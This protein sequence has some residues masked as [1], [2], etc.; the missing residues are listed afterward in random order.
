MPCFPKHVWPSSEEP[1][2]K[3]RKLAKRAGGLR[4]LLRQGLAEVRPSL[5]EALSAKKNN[6][7][8]RGKEVD[9]CETKRK[10]E[11]VLARLDAI[12]GR[13]EPSSHP[14]GDTVGSAVI[15]LSP[16]LQVEHFTETAEVLTA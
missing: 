15:E 5:A 14:R 2:P 4:A 7:N 3:Q 8:E 9:W 1:V 12:Q 16:S 13:A 6:N 10:L 11:E